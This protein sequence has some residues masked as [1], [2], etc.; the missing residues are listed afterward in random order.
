MN[1]ID[2]LAVDSAGGGAFQMPWNAVAGLWESAELLDT[3]RC[4]ARR[5]SIRS[6]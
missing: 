4:C 5:L 1:R 6:V 3:P 2:H